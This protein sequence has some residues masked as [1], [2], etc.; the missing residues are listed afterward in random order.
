LI[1]NQHHALG[2][3]RRVANGAANSIGH[4]T[5]SCGAIDD[6]DLFQGFQC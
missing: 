1:A 6:V 3:L 4:Q 5:D 2:K